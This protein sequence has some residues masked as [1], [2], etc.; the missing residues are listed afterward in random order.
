MFL[1]LGTSFV[2]HEIPGAEFIVV[3]MMD[4][5]QLVGTN[6]GLHSAILPHHIS[7]SHRGHHLHCNPANT[8]SELPEGT[9]ASISALPERGNTMI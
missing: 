9:S 7:R 8:V 3:Q 4:W 2:H 5:N 6:V 1:T